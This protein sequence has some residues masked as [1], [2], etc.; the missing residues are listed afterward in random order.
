MLAAG[1]HGDDH[2]GAPAKQRGHGIMQLPPMAT[3]LPR[4]C[5]G[6]SFQGHL[7]R[8]IQRRRQKR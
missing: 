1:Y 6:D 7:R 2:P 5:R 3:M 4:Y 8:K